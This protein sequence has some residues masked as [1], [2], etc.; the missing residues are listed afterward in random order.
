MLS[1][2]FSDAFFIV[3]FVHLYEF[4]FFYL[5]LHISI[6]LSNQNAKATLPAIISCLSLAFLKRREYSNTRTAAFLKQI[7]TTCLHT[8]T[9]LSL[10]LLTFARQLLHRYSS[11]NSISQ[12]L[13]NESDII[14]SGAYTP[15]VMDPEHSN[16]FATSAWEL[17]LLKFHIDPSMGK[18]HAQAC[19][20]N[21]M[22]SY[23]TESPDRIFEE[24]MKF[25]V[26]KGYIGCRIR[27]KKHPFRHSVPGAN[28][29][30]SHEKKKRG[31][32]REQYRFVKARKTTGLHLKSF[33]EL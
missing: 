20:E 7:L 18:H 9:H 33:Q 15:D 5:I 31:R 13:E 16:P 8:E 23:P 27:L 1:A 22:L 19:A 4:S 10:P 12:L 14:T 28:N 29:A 26:E 17:G 6:R 11:T 21:K 2:L 25:Y 3:R 32:N 24:R 30:E